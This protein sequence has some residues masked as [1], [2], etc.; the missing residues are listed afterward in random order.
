MNSRF[1]SN[2]L[3]AGLIALVLIA[4]GFALSFYN[5]RSTPIEAPD[6]EE[7]T[8]AE[9][10]VQEPEEGFIEVTPASDESLSRIALIH[11]SHDA[12]TPDTQEK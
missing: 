10:S 4:I 12:P 7:P 11:S 2:N 5:H 8:V 6:I 1:K 9:T 3:F